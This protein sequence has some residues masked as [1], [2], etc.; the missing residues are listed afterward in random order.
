MVPRWRQRDIERGCE[1]LKRMVDDVLDLFEA[2]M[3]FGTEACDGFRIAV[4]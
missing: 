3:S 1:G 4:S 2:P